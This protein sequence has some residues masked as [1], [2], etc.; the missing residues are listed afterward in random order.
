MSA[1]PVLTAPLSRPERRLCLHA[2]GYRVSQNARS[3]RRG[4]CHRS[5][6][7]RVIFR[8]LNVSIE[9][10]DGAQVEPRWSGVRGSRAL[11]CVVS[12]VVER[13]RITVPAIVCRQRLVRCR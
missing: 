9:A 3:Q 12:L 6:V 5:A 13:G 2:G 10:C 11:C 7:T 4:H 1:D 8:G